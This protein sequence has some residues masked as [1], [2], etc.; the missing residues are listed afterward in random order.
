MADT[1]IAFELLSRNSTSNTM[2]ALMSLA[3]RDEPGGGAIRSSLMTGSRGVYK[4]RVD[5]QDGGG[6]YALARAGFVM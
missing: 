4:L 1:D 3:S 5:H 6:L 2:V